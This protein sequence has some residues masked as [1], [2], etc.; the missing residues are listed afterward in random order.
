MPINKNQ[1]IGR[2]KMLKRLL[3]IS[4]ATGMAAALALP[5]G[6]YAEG[7]EATYDAIVAA[8]ADEPAVQWCTGMEPSESQ[9]IVDAFVALYPDVPE[10]NDFECSGEA[11]TQRVVTE[12]GAGAPQVDILDTD[13]EI[14]EAL[15]EGDL[16]HVQD[17]SVFDGTPLQ[18][19]PR[20]LSYG[21]RILSVGQAHRVI[22]FNPSII[23]R[24]DAPK[25][26]EECGDPKYKGIMA[27]DVRPTFFELMEDAG[28]PWGED[29]MQEWAAAIAANEPLWT[30]GS[31]QNF[32]VLSSGERGLNCGQQ[33]HGLFRGGRTD[34]NDANAVVQF[35]IPKQVIVRDYIRLG[36]AP[37]PLA[38][39][40]TL[41][42]AAFM[43]SDKGQA[44]IGVA[45]AGY[46]S[47]YLEGSFTHGAVEAAGAETLQ[48]PQEQ[49]AAVAERMNEI[50][51][52]EWGFPK[53]IPKKKK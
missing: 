31:S 42:F 14:L 21:G 23:S 6:A 15:E 37:E 32:Q 20:Y 47:P 12:W 24:E 17:W 28:G 27:A 2:E 5:G 3:S 19:N 53:P 4:A 39:N 38:P 29:K 45:N 34:P 40:G 8:A 9:P 46:S 52:T 49:I 44:A 48:A 25:S 16:T 41:L 33:L 7:F 22:W 36:L 18:I 35:I 26:F 10:P 11:A 30:R 51:L 43:A 1:P 13:T 50:I